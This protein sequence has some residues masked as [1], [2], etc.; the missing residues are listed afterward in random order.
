VSRKTAANA[1]KR[2]AAAPKPRPAPRSAPLPWILWCAGILLLTLIV[3]LPTLDNEFTNWDDTSY[4]TRNPNIANPDFN[5]LLTTDLNGN[6]HPLT[7]WS[8]ALNYRLSGLNPDSYHW[9]TLLFHLAN[10]A[11]VFLFLRRLS[12][13]RLWTSVAGSL[14]F[15]IHPMHVESVAWISERKDVLY[16]FFFLIG[17]ILYLR[18]LNKRN[19]VWLI[20]TLAA[21]VLSL[22]SK[23]AA[24]VFPVVLLLLDWYKRRRFAPSVFLEKIPF[25]ALSVAMGL[26]TLGAQQATGAMAA[27][28]GAFH[29]LLFASYGTVMYVVKLFLPFGL[30]AIYPYPNVEGRGLGSE[31]YIA[32]A[33]L[34]LLLPVA[35]IASRRSRVVGFGLGFF[36]INIALVLQFATV[37]QAVMADRYTYLPYIGL[38]LALAWWLDDPPGARSGPPWAR[39]LIAACL[40]LLIPISLYQTWR[41]C[42]VWQNSETLWTDTIENY[43]R[44]VYFAYAFRGS[45]LREANKQL[46][47]ARAD[48]DEAIALNPNVEIAWNEKGMLLANVG[49]LDS[50]LI[51]FDNAVRLKP[52]FAAA[53]S[54]RGAIRLGR[55]EAA[56]AVADLT[57]ALEANP[58]LFNA[59]TNR[60]L[61]FIGLGDHEKAAADLR[62]AL[63]LEPA[64]PN[65]HVYRNALGLE[66]AALNKYRDAIGAFDAAIQS[67]PDDVTPRREYY[68]NRSRAWW[69]LGDR[70]R[71]LG[72]AQEARRLGAA[73][74]P[75]YLRTIGG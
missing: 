39:P 48:L 4:V 71:A 49:Q 66:L 42:D 13:G 40:V 29:K 74:D 54:N 21:F 19:W 65:N 59:H 47:R 72:D 33:A 68:F 53:W 28:V 5:T 8:F 64:H 22:A 50:A 73:I 61:A 37:G 36:L 2:K 6:Y 31:F 69:A 18:Y 12:G 43:P 44:R 34:L 55:G 51:C 38:F 26:L 30:S 45:Y 57:S 62:S 9:L 20:A 25:F 58:R 27:H 7:M 56:A 1:Q 14:F 52:D 17:L 41:R 24:V 15:G 32:F 3:Y 70:A 46:D 63:E 35:V 16:A 10:T 60:A 75:E 23:P 11:L 67:A